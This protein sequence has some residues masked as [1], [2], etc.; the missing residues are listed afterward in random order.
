MKTLR[1]LSLISDP[2]TQINNLNMFLGK[3]YENLAVTDS[4]AHSGGVFDVG[5]NAAPSSSK[6]KSLF[7]YF[8]FQLEI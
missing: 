4:I 1:T 8:L 7:L 5:R 2:V 3:Q 6:I